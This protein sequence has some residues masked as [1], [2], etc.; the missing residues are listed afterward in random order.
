MGGLGSG[1]DHVTSEPRPCIISALK[2]EHSLVY[3]PEDIRLKTEHFCTETIPLAYFAIP[4][5][6][7]PR[8]GFPCMV[9]IAG[10][11]ARDIIIKAAIMQPSVHQVHVDL[12]LIRCVDWPQTLLLRETVS[13][14]AVSPPSS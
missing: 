12:R 8:E 9:L 4:H 14:R 10:L 13:Y 7:N 11:H 3:R 2:T 5:K 6:G 1:D